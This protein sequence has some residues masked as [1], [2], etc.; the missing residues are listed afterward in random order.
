VHARAAV[1]LDPINAQAVGLL[2][3][4]SAMQGKLDEGL[5]LAIQSTRLNPSNAQAYHS[6]AAIH[7]WRGEADR[8]IAA[9]E[10]AIRL[11]PNDPLLHMYL[12]NQSACLY[13]QRQYEH[14]VDAARLT[15]QRAP[16]YPMGWRGLANALG[17]TGRIDEARDALARFLELVPDYTSEAVA[18][19]T[20]PFRDEAE[21]QHYLE[22]LR[23]AGWTG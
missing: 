21:F 9:A 4:V 14:A 3:G 1:A 16:H 7:M 5:S 11:S 19:E 17:Q 22:G 18:R 10:R 13:G 23:R 15:A 20:A 6:L 12:S 2:G 8:G